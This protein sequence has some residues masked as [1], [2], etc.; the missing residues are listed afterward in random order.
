MKSKTDALVDRLRR[1]ASRIARSDVLA[2]AGAHLGGAGLHV[3]AVDREA[4]DHLAQREVQAV[5][6]EVARPAVLLRDAVEAARE[7]VQLARHRRAQ[8]QAS[9]PGRPG[10]R[11]RRGR[12]AAAGTDVRW[13]ARPPASTNRA[14]ERVQE[15]VAGRAV[16]GPLGRQ[17]LVAGQDL[18]DHDV[19]RAAR[20]AWRR[21]RCRRRRRG[22]CRRRRRPPAAGC[23]G[24]ASDPAGRRRG[25]CA[26]R[27]TLPA[28]S[29][30]NTL[31]WTAS[32][33]WAARRGSRPGR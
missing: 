13:R 18:L 32:S 7:H 22:R 23:A 3:G 20:W 31:A 33:T 2:I 9:W 1:L 28:R 30:A 29:R 15:V 12:R 14:V 26:G 17:R 25:R 19:G 8:D 27:S 11:T 6:R 16:H 5:E 4:G 24:S 10:R 21:R